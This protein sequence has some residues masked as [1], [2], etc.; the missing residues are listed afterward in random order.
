MSGALGKESL[1]KSI[2]AF[3]FSGSKCPFFSP[4]A[5]NTGK[6]EMSNLKGM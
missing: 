3:I 6:A 5:Y 2:C 1:R 4:K